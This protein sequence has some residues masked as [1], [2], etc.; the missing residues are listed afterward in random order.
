[1]TDTSP[2][3]FQ[4]MV[5]CQVFECAAEVSYPLD[6]LRWWNDQPICENC[7]N[8]ERK[9]GSADWSDLEPLTIK[10]ARA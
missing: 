9:E 1:M 8:E 7:Y 6:M 3:T 4:A 5:G 10:Q 2:K